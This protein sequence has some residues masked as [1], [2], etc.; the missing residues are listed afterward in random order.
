[1]KTNKKIVITGA[2]GTGKTS[3]INALKNKNYKCLPEISRQITLEARENGIEQLFLTDPLLFSRKLLEGRIKQYKEAE[4]LEGTV[5]LDRGIPDVIA[6]MDY[7]KDDY[8][9]YFNDACKK[10]H[11]KQVFLLPSWEDI[12]TSD[13]ERYENYEEAE[14]IHH[15]LKAAYENCGYDLIEVPKDTVENRVEFIL[16]QLD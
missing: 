1:M 5:F 15:Y 16:N 13:N 9:Q 11:Y 10:Y 14:Q 3:V 4:L 8:P 6:Y 7:A 2:P 12:Y